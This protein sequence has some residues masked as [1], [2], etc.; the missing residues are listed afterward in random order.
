MPNDDYFICPTCGEEVR[1]GS[2]AC[3]GCGS[4]ERTGWGENSGADGLDLPDEEFDY[5]E[6][7]KKEFGS[8]K[9]IKPTSVSWFWWL[10]GVV[11]LLAFLLGWVFRVF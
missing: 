4:D 8:E 5:D 9:N 6:F 1:V 10:V 7:C 11:L 2:K 3:P